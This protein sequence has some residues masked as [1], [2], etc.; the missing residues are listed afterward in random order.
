MGATQSSPDPGRESWSREGVIPRGKRVEGCEPLRDVHI[1]LLGDST[2][3]HKAYCVDDPS[4]E[5]VL[6]AALS[7]VSP[8]AS[9]SSSDSQTPSSAFGKEGTTPTATNSVTLCARDGALMTAIARQANTMPDH[10]THIVIS[11]GGNDA[12]GDI[13][14]LHRK[15]ADVQEAAQLL[16]NFVDEFIAKLREVMVATLQK[17]RWGKED[18]DRKN[19]VLCSVYI[20]QFGP[21]GVTNID[22]A[23]VEVAALLL[24][25][26]I[27]NL[28]FELSIPVI[29]LSRVVTSEECLSNPIEPN[30]KGAERMARAILEVVRVH[31][32]REDHHA[33]FPQRKL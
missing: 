2:I 26:T 31:D 17:Y 15:C 27:Q 14:I 24:S 19:I 33:I 25:K 11:V 22:Q 8:S 13:S 3:D 30:G 7:A 10:A 28:A 5:E 9:H 16:K 18:K 1:A 23:S 4:V 21:F 12:L 32:F 29:D 6:R 20:P